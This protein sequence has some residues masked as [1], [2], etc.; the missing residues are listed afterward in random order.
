MIRDP[1]QDQPSSS[2]PSEISGKDIFDVSKFNAIVKYEAAVNGPTIKYI[3]S[4]VWECVVGIN[5]AWKTCLSP[6]V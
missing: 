4:G 1:K 5:V 3:L 2:A 6:I